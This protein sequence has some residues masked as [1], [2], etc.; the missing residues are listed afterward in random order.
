MFIR[1]I[2]SSD[3]INNIINIHKEAFPGFFLTKLGDSFLK[4][5]YKSVIKNGSSLFVGAFN[6]NELVGFCCTAIVSKNFNKVII[7]DNLIVFTF[8]GLKLLITNPRYL[9]GLFR[10]MTKKSSSVQDRS[11]Y[12]ELLSI[13][14]LNK[15]QGFGYG[16][17]MIQYA[18][19]EL[20]KLNRSQLS[21]TTDLHNNEK[22]IN[23]YQKLGYKIL[24]EFTAWPN[25]KMYRMIKELDINYIPDEQNSFNQKSYEESV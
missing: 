1:T 5:Y 22:T 20:I 12:A 18:E 10:N 6:Q 15:Y 13:A 8:L 9:Y 17:K 4:V 16:Q 11:D 3:H 23:F 14:V 24:Y 25:R 7:R 2:S 19:Y 21:L